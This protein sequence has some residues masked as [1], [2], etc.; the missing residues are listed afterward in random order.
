TCA[1]PIYLALVLGRVRRDGHDQLSQAGCHDTGAP[2]EKPRSRRGVSTR[3]FE[4]LLQPVAPALEDDPLGPGRPGLAP[5]E[6]PIPNRLAR[7][8]A[9]L[10]GDD[11][12]MITGVLAD[13]VQA[14]RHRLESPADP[15]LLR[16]AAAAGQKHRGHRE[17]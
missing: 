9:G 2:K 15:L 6:Q 13:E 4:L 16:A 5:E 17:H 3:L 10:V 12:E 8:V 14:L 11:L 1:L 7:D